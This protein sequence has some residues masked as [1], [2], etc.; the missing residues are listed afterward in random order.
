MAM[1]AKLG[2]QAARMQLFRPLGSG[3]SDW[4][5]L[6]RIESDWIELNWIALDW[7][8]LDQAGGWNKFLC[9]SKG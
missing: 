6:H 2:L 9:L 4:I 1:A 7:K 3:H 8:L 5:G